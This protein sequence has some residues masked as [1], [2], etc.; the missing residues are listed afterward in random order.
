[1][2]K[3]TPRIMNINPQTYASMASSKSLYPLSHS[4]EINNTIQMLAMHLKRI[5]HNHTRISQIH[6]TQIFKAIKLLNSVNKS[7]RIP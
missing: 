3:I 4:I 1:M 7:V 2:V 6:H 5:K